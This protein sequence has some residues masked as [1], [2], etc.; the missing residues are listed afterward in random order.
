MDF[1]TEI[2][3]AHR[4][5]SPHIR[6]TYLERSENL[7]SI[8]GGDV[9]LKLENL[10][11]TGAFKAR[12]AL[13]KLLSFDRQSLEKGVITASTGN[14]G[15]AVSFGANIVGNKA[16]V[17]V[18][19]IASPSKVAAIK[20]L[21]A[22]IV[23]F[24]DD[25]V[26]TENHAR[27]EAERIGAA[28]VPPYNDPDVIAGQGTIAK[29]IVE[30]IGVPDKILVSLGGG[31]LISGIAG[32]LKAV[33]DKCEVV[34]CSAANSCVMMQSIGLGK[35]VG[36]LPSLPT[37]SD[38]TSGGIEN[39]SITFDY[40]RD[41]VDRYLSFTEE[42]IHLAMRDFIDVHHMLIE[43]AAG[44]ALA[45]IGSKELDQKGK[46]T[47]VVVCGANIGTETLAGVLA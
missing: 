44:V 20:R 26:E 46:T 28:Y 12:G 22:E 8:A 40:C 31:G 15:A 10:Q 37:I 41:L 5:I 39:D 42:E 18:S 29:E 3:T 35:L 32:Y 47:V 7:S 16:T 33:S 34:A 30:D 11:H 14:H 23:E 19:R 9:F 24:G 21:G 4:R 2:E 27:A 45:G 36:D 25:C 1:L 43:G 13:N 6:R 38:G 17:Y